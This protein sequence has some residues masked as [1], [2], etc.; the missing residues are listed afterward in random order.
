MERIAFIIPLGVY[1]QMYASALT[2]KASLFGMAKKISTLRVV[3]FIALALTSA[4]TCIGGHI[5]SNVMNNKNTILP[6]LTLCYKA[7]NFEKHKI[8]SPEAAAPVLR[9][10][11]DA[12]LLEY[13]EEFILLCLN[14]ANDTIGY[15][16]ISSGGLTY[17][18]ADP[19]MIFAIALK[20]GATSIIISHNHPSGNKYPS[21]QDIDLTMKVK[22]SGSLLEI[23]LIDHI[24]ITPDSFYSFANEGKI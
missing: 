1:M 10:M 24:I 9:S 23:H 21:Q 15:S 13:R 7:G 4:Y 8:N 3:F 12:D 20:C 11:Y 17:T 14:R 19:R 2:V 16:K 18:T 22:Q 5:N 6:E